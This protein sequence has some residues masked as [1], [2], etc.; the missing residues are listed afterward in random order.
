MKEIIL[1]N[2]AIIYL[3]VENEKYK[4]IIKTLPYTYPLRVKM[5]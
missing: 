4:N 2:V 5:L 1:F 3:A